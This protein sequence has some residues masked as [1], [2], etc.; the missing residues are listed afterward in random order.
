MENEQALQELTAQ[1]ASIGRWLLKVFDVKEV[2]YDYTWQGEHK[3]GKKVVMTLVSADSDQYCLGVIKKKGK[4]PKATQ[5]F[6]T[7]KTKLATGTIWHT[8][9]V[10]LLPSEKP[11]YISAPVK[12]VIDLAATVC[13][14]VLQST[15]PDTNKHGT[16]YQPGAWY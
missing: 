12:S 16:D 14:G 6:K 2:D 5:D 10:T 4:E 1:S 3:K 13:V 15:R 7:L 8:K 9:K 11:L